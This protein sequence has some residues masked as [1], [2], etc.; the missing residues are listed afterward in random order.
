LFGEEFF[1]SEMNVT[2]LASNPFVAALDMMGGF[3][4]EVVTYVSRSIRDGDVVR[5]EGR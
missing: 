2:V 3:H 4:A 5:V 1:V